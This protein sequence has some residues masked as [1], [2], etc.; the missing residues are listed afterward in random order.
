MSSES[1]GHCTDVPGDAAIARDRSAP[2]SPRPTLQGV[3]GPGSQTLPTRHSR[4]I[5]CLPE[6]TS[7]GRGPQQRLSPIP[8]D[9]RHTADTNS[10]VTTAARQP[11]APS[12]L[13]AQSFLELAILFD[14][15]DRSCG[16]MAIEIFHASHFAAG[17][18][19]AATLPST[20]PSMSR[21]LLSLFGC[22]AL[23]LLTG[24]CCGGFG[25]RGCGYGGGCGS[26]C[27]TAYAAPAYGTAYAAPAYG[28]G[29]CGCQ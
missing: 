10:P 23:S 9:P 13:I 14:R 5:G 1:R 8:S 11:K 2:I 17:F 27:G 20:D 7:S 3:G 26:A 25:S 29:S 16:L 24:C 28:G 19:Q 6:V 21:L 4:C 18:L 22:L 12:L 15:K